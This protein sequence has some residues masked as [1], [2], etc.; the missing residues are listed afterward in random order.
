LGTNTGVLWHY[1]AKIES[2]IPEGDE[3][4]KILHA[5]TTLQESHGKPTF[6]QRYTEFITA[7]ADY[8]TLLTPFIPQLTQMLGHVLK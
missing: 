5:L 6:A 4:R 2:G 3:R 8:V 1:Q 7:A